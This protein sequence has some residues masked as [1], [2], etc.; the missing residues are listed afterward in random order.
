MTLGV[1]RLGDW[2]GMVSVIDAALGD[3]E[4][5]LG[6]AAEGAAH[7]RATHLYRHKVKRVLENML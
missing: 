6:V 2:E 4:R 7:V 5:R 3:T 1:W